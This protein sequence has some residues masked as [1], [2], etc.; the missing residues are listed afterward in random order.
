M[1]GTP[2]GGEH[3]YDAMLTEKIKDQVAITWEAFVASRIEE[4]GR[5]ARYSSGLILLLHGVQLSFG[6]GV[7]K[8][9]TLVVGGACLFG[10]RNINNRLSFGSERSE[11]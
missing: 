1:P 4:A 9:E 8:P 5:H 11:Q 2:I 10:L 3:D 7:A 6:R